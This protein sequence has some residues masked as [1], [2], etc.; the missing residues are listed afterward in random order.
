MTSTWPGL[1]GPGSAQRGSAPLKPSDA[2]SGQRRATRPG[3]PGPTQATRGCPL[4]R[5]ARS[6]R[7]GWMVPKLT[8][9]GPLRL[10]VRLSREQAVGSVRVLTE[11]GRV[12]LGISLAVL[13]EEDA[14]SV[15]GPA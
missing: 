10:V 2:G 6:R 1:T 11:I 9:P 14:I 12:A 4:P 15:I 5:S 3:R 8:V 7:R 13:G